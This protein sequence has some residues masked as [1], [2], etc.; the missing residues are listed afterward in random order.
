MKSESST[1]SAVSAA[2]VSDSNEPDLF[3]P[4]PSA[5]KTPSAK[6]SCEST[7]PISQSTTTFENLK[8]TRNPPLQMELTSSAAGSR[9]C[10][11]PGVKP[12]SSEAQKMTVTSG[13][14]WLPLLKNYGLDGSLAKMCEALLTNHWASNAACLIWKASGIKPSHLLLQLAA[15]VSR[16]DAT[17]F[18]LWPTPKARD[19]KDG[20]SA[21][22]ANRSSPDLGKL[23]G[24]SRATGSLNPACVEWLMGFPE[25]WTD[26]KPSATPSSRKSSS[27]SDAQS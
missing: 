10:A 27:K 26:L 3:A 6:Q 8:E 16:T 13:Q 25:G 15:S 24:Q 12:G 7:G 4:S 21:G 11:S 23:V 17:G 2:S 1:C 9:N 14:R 22:T 20:T 5:S 19:W 18:G